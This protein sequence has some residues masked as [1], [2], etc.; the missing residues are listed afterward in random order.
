[1]S[2]ATGWIVG[3]SDGTQW[4]K[5]DGGFPIWVY[6]RDQA[7]RYHRREDAEAVHVE[8]DDAWVVV[9]YNKETS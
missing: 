7:T 1:M 3:N 5:W 8:D 2:E 4:R 9:P 6:D